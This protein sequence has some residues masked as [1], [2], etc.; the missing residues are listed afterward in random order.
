MHDSRTRMSD[1]WGML[2]SDWHSPLPS[3]HSWEHFSTANNE[4]LWTI[5]RGEL[6]IEPGGEKDRQTHLLMCICPDQPISNI[7]VR[8]ANVW[9]CMCYQ[10]S[11]ALKLSWI[12]YREDRIWF[13]LLVECDNVNRVRGKNCNSVSRTPPSPTPPFNLGKEVICKE[14][15]LFILLWWSERWLSCDVVG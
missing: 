7:S 10:F 6:R 12:W 11:L 15:Y 2:L 9:H 4:P 3:S 8:A 1:E 5:K 13:Y 14:L